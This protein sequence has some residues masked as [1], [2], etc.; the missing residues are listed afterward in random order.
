MGIEFDVCVTDTDESRLTGE[1][2]A[3]F[4]QRLAI[5][6]AKAAQKQVICDDTPTAILAADTIVRLDSQVFGKPFDYQDAVSIW[7]NLSEQTHQVMTGVCL[8]ISD[9]PGCVRLKQTLSVTEV[10]FGKI[11]TVEMQRY[12]ATAEPLDKA[13]AYAIQGLA[14]A[15]VKQIN[16]SYSNVVGLPLREVNQLLKIINKNWL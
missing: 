3:D 4:V 6:K 11:D 5:D 9:G 15:W 10:Q 1:S 12:W 13:G 16:G 8:L 7:T 14:S 2:P